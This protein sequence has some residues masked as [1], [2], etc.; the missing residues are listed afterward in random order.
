MVFRSVRETVTKVNWITGIAGF[1]RSFLV[2]M[3][4]GRVIWVRTLMQLAFCILAANFWD[5]A[6]RYRSGSLAHQALAPYWN[7]AIVTSSAA[8]ILMLVLGRRRELKQREWFL[9]LAILAVLSPITAL[10]L[11]HSAR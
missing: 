4:P 11:L 7:M 10:L 2:G 5:V 1:K 3:A 6:I 8:L 9:N